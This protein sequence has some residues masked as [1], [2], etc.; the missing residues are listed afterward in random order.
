MK[1]RMLRGMCSVTRKDRIKN[2]YIREIVKVTEIG[3]KMQERRL[4]WYGHVMRKDED[5]VGRRI[6]NME[7][8]GH[9]RRGR[10]KLR[11]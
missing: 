6:M 2:E 8:E 3:K 1:M 5:Y 9:R 11:W 7:V 4:H 10:P